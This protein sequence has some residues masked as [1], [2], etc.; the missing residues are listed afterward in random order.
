MNWKDPAFAMSLAAALVAAPVAASARVTGVSLTP[1]TL[2]G[3]IACPLQQI[4]VAQI[5]STAPGKVRFQWTTSDGQHSPVQE[6][7]FD[8]PGT[9]PVSYLWMA[10]ATRPHISGWVRVRTSAPNAVTARAPV[11]VSCRP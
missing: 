8:S 7:V 6:A 2:S 10:L 1:A 5:T 11:S 4:F 3:P 9:K